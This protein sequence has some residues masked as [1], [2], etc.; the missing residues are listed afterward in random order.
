MI[1]SSW[2]AWGRTGIQ[3]HLR[4]FRHPSV[5]SETNSLEMETVQ[6]TLPKS[7]SWSQ[8]VSKDKTQNP[9][10]GKEEP[11]RNSWRLENI[12]GTGNISAHVSKP[13]S[14]N[15]QDVDGR[16][17]W[18]KLLLSKSWLQ[19]IQHQT[20]M[21]CEQQVNCSWGKLN[22]MHGLE[23]ETAYRHQNIILSWKF[24]EPGL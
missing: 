13:T 23:K 2:S 16:T 5:H 17:S 6:F 12:T 11:M 10:W 14:L 1:E 22:S 3:S 19:H 7:E 18:K 4:V 9:Q 24:R 8:D 21:F 20:K 15:R